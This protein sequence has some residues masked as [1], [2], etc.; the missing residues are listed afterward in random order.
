MN[1][2]PNKRAIIVGLFVILGISFLVAGILVIGNARETF[3]SKIRL[4]TLF[5]D[6]SGL[7]KG[8][9]IW[10]SGVKVGIVKDVEFQGKSQV[11]I[12]MNVETKVQQYIMKD[13]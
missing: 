3:K 8:S 13:A 4:I 6:V 10:F 9:N 11:R 12:I 7:Q 2:S 1:E 5:D